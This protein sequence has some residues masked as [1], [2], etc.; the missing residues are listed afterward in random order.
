MPTGS[1]TGVKYKWLLKRG[2]ASIAIHSN[3]KKNIAPI[4]IELGYEALYGEKFINVMAK[5]EKVITDLGFHIDRDVVSRVDLQVTLAGIS[6]N[7]DVVKAF[8]ENRFVTRIAGL[9]PH[10]KRNVY[11]T[12]TWGDRKNRKV[13]V[14]IYNKFLEAF[15]TASC[16]NLGQKA[17]DLLDLFGPKV[18][19]YFGYFK[20]PEVR[21]DVLVRVEF[22]L[23]RDF[24][25]E[26]K[27][28]SYYDL[29]DDMP[30]LIKYLTEDYFK[31]VTKS[32]DNSTHYYESPFDDWWQ[33]V[34]RAFNEVF[35]AGRSFVTKRDRRVS[36]VAIEDLIKQFSGCV[37]SVL[38][39]VPY[40]GKEGDEDTM[41]Y[42]VFYTMLLSIIQDQAKDMYKDYERK[43]KQFRGNLEP[44]DMTDVQENISRKMSAREQRQER[45]AKDKQLEKAMLEKH[46]VVRADV[47]DRDYDGCEEVP[48]KVQ[49]WLTIDEAAQ[50]YGR[51]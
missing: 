19:G 10:I 6:F 3:P 34:I 43:R 20:Y 41:P 35:V 24:L 8:L 22:R 15:K 7:D 1:G 12:F 33:K 5:I 32:K 31:V 39:K 42:S 28:E 9:N 2:G 4:R 30:Y 16:S 45:L 51:A 46:Q 21:D 11:E 38:S 17:V 23:F 14:C 29:L 49:E 25:R 50:R 36:A 47:S 48:Y 13:Q 18:G 27:I 37:T 26:H 40:I 44:L